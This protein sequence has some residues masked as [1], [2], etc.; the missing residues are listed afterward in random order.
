MLQ[1]S[2]RLLNHFR[3]EFEQEVPA[4]IHNRDIADDGAPQWSPEFVKWLTAK[5][6]DTNS[7]IV[8]SEHRLRTRRAMRKLR[9]TSARGFEVTWRVFNGEHVESTTVWLNDR[10]HRNAVPLPPGRTVHYTTK[11]AL[12]ILYSS[13]LFMEWAY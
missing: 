11:D 5:E 8:N 2:E 6:S 4:R 7:Y 9:S 3:A 12:A 13:L 10:A 1:Q